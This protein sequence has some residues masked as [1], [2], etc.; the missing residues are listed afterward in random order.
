MLKLIVFSVFGCGKPAE[1]TILPCTQALDRLE[2]HDYHVIRS[3]E[4]A[5]RLVFRCAQ[6][7]IVSVGAWRD[8]EAALNIRASN[9]S[10][11]IAIGL[12]G[13]GPTWKSWNGRWRTD[14]QT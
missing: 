13:A 3:R 2:Q 4:K 6:Q 7:R 14:N 5:V 12:G 10:I 9:A 11:P 1:T 8:S